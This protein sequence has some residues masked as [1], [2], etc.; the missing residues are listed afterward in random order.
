M[1]WPERSHTLPDG[2]EL[3][4]TYE[5][6]PVGWVVH[7]GGHEDRP[8][9]GRDIHD[10]LVDLL[11]PC[12]ARWPS[13]FIEAANDLAAQDTPLGRRYACPCCCY[14]TLD[15]APTG[16][17]NICKVCFWE[18]DNVQFHDPDYEGAPTRSA[19]TRPARTFA[20][21]ASARPASSPTSAR[22]F[23]KSS[24]NP[25]DFRPPS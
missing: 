12:E 18:D 3:R 17:Y 21:T 20:R 14:L 19:S 11:E 5:G 8:V 6:D 13:W 24:P 15:E 7:L 25:A 1:S 23:P 2:R 4:A 9:A 22:R 16:T 10:V